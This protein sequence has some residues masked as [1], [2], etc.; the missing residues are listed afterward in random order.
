MFLDYI[1]HTLSIT[2]TDTIES[3]EVGQFGRSAITKKNTIILK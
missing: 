2:E 1:K 3:G